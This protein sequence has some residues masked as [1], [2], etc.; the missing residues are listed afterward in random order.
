MES[1]LIRWLAAAVAAVTVMAQEYELQPLATAY[2]QGAVVTP[3]EGDLASGASSNPDTVW[4]LNGID[5]RWLAVGNPNLLNRRDKVT[6]RF[7]LSPWVF[8]GPVKK[9][10][11]CYRQ[12]AFGYRPEEIIIEHFLTERWMLSGKDL[13]S[14]QTETLANYVSEVDAGQLTMIVDVTEAVNRDLR[15]GFGW[16]TFRIASATAEREANPENAAT[17]VTVDNGTLQLILEK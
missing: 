5:G 14:T 6:V 12:T 3:Q 4:Y 1:R 11:L 10:W 9:A 15:R 7:D 13:I 16:T 17:G 8:P 2:P